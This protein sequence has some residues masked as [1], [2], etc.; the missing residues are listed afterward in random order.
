[1]DD[2]FSLKGWL[3]E[4]ILP[5]FNTYA[6]IKKNIKN[7]FYYG[8]KLREDRDWDYSYLQ[9]IINIKLNKMFDYY[10]ESKHCSWTSEKD[11]EEY[12]AFKALRICKNISNR[13]EEDSYLRSF[14]KL[15]KKYGSY[16]F[17]T[18][19]D[20]NAFKITKIQRD[21]ETESNREDIKKLEEETRRI[22]YAIQVRDRKI[23]FK[24]LEVYM[25]CWWD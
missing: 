6:T 14:R 5:V 18:V 25:P 21:G 11:S 17:V 15:D 7:M 13:I 9:T 22:G 12:K 23:L 24:L 19:K 4:K 3:I 2:K 16:K 8:W 1:M 10:S 20:E